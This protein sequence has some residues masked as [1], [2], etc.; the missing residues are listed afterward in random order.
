MGLAAACGPAALARAARGE[1]PGPLAGSKPNI[2]FIFSDDL[3]YRDLSSYGQKLYRTPN[4]DRL[5]TGGVRF[6]QAYAGS[7]ECAP[8][9]ASLMTGMHMGH[10]R[11]RKNSSV[12]GQDHLLA[13]DITVAEVL[14]RAGYATGFVG[15]WGI[16]LPGTEG[17]PYKQGFDYAY[18]FYDQGRA[19]GYYPDFLMAN[20]KRVVLTGNHGFDMERLYDYNRRPVGRLGGVANEYDKD[21][22]LVAAG[23]AETARVSNSEDLVQEAALKFIRNNG[24]GRFFLYYATQIPHGPVITPSLGEFKDKDWSLKNKEWA[25]MILH[26]DRGVG[27]ITA[28]LKELGIERNTLIFFAGDNGYSQWGYFAR[29][30]WLD[31]PLFRNRGPWRGGKFTCMEGGLRVPFF[32]CWPGRIPARQSEHVC[33]LYDFLATAADLAGVKLEH[34]TDGISLVPELENRPD[35]Q[36][37]H[38]YLYWESCKGKLHEQAVRMGP[39]KAY[40]PGPDKPTQLYRIDRD[41]ACRRDLAKD[42]REIVGKIERIFREARTDSEW[43]INPGESAAAIKAKTEKARRTKSMQTSTRANT[44]YTRKSGGKAAKSKQR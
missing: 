15:K 37:E 6:N 40:R 39:W 31:D 32:A 26:L 25:S 44:T 36:K 14:T 35:A 12:R 28:L 30:R 43:Y 9:R 13:E 38:E 8:S 10:C 3:S 17:V 22:R 18:G 20:D 41:V 27:R 42:N 34:E 11:I 21:G 4:L 2:I 5:A 23:V 33:A 29:K 1:A 16:G 7:P 24:D 19:H